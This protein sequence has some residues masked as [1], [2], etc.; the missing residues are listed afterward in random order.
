M[1]EYQ[2]M[3]DL[4]EAT[5]PTP[6]EESALRTLLNPLEAEDETKEEQEEEED[7]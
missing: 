4:N 1:N 7:D 6:A 3:P 5:D 2:E